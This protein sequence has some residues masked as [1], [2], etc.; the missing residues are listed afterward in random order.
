MSLIRNESGCRAA[1]PWMRSHDSLGVVRR[2]SEVA[3]LMRLAYNLNGV[4]KT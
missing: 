1:P 2:V 3:S 4:I